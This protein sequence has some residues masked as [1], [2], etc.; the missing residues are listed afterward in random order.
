MRH[1]E[2]L[3]ILLKTT[4]Q[5]SAPVRDDAPEQAVKELYRLRL[6]HKLE[7]IKTKPSSAYNVATLCAAAGAAGQA[8][9]WLEKAF[10]ERDPMLVAVSTDPAFDS[11]RGEARFQRL[12]KRMGFPT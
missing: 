7:V 9:E 4:G 3:D 10:Q 2:A 8:M 11:L 1:K 12:L 5:A 6:K